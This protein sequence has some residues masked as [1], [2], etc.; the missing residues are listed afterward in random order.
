[1]V[2]EILFTFS[3]K[4]KMVF[5]ENDFLFQYSKSGGI[6]CFCTKLDHGNVL[7]LFSFYLIPIAFSIVICLRHIFGFVSLFKCFLNNLVKER[8]DKT[9]KKFRIILWGFKGNLCCCLLFDS[10]LGSSIL[11]PRYLG[12]LTSWI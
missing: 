3:K 12:V 6:Y 8:K 11:S 10:I 9:G 7:V 5:M 2:K 1:M 4:N